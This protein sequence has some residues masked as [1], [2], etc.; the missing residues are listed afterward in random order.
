MAPSALDDE[1]VQYQFAGI[2]LRGPEFADEASRHLADA[3]SDLPHRLRTSGDSGHARLRV[4]HTRPPSE[5]L[6]L[7]RDVL[8]AAVADGAY[9][10]A[11][12][13]AESRVPATEAETVGQLD[14]MLTWLE[15][16]GER[17]VATTV[18]LQPHL[19][20]D[21]LRQ[22][23]VQQ[24][25]LL[26]GRV[27]VLRRLDATGRSDYVNTLTT[28]FDRGGDV[29]RAAE[30]MYMHPNTLRYRLRRISALTGLDLS[31]PTDRLV[32]ELQLR[33]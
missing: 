9:C 29:V 18:E 23:A 27:E 15:V 13:L 20:L 14:Q 10:T 8:E 22:L 3:L 12:V 24:P 4:G 11:A 19:V 17:R 32:A 21:L 26:R 31:D 2:A 6:R 30:A 33:L 5:V 25:G 7:V 1:H 16:R 28:Y